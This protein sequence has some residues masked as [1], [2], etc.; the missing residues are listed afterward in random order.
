MKPLDRFYPTSGLSLFLQ[1]DASAKIS[2]VALNIDGL[3]AATAPLDPSVTDKLTVQV[4]AASF[5]SVGRMLASLEWTRLDS[6]QSYRP[7]EDCRV[8]QLTAQETD[9]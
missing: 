6:D 8:G 7:R 9:N 3:A 5:A 4:A 1:Q 2:A